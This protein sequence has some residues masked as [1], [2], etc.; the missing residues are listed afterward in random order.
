MLIEC[1]RKKVIE[2]R[3]EPMISAIDNQSKL[4]KA[5]LN[6]LGEESYPYWKNK[7]G[8][9]LLSNTEKKPTRVIQFENSRLIIAFEDMISINEFKKVGIKIVQIVKNVFKEEF[10]IISR[11]GCRFISV[12]SDDNQNSFQGCLDSVNSKY[13]NPNLPLSLPIVDSKATIHFD[14]VHCNIG[15]VKKDESWVKEY[16]AFTQDDCPEFGYGIDV[17]AFLFGAE[18]DD[19]NAVSKHLKMVFDLLSVVTKEIFESFEV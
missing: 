15:P 10:T 1:L 4:I 12:Y 3:F 2:L 17:D 19:N 16:F 8:V 14:N 5:L 6:E 11:V 9:S 13:L 18:F 7:D